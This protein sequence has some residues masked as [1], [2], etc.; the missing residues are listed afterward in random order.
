MNKHQKVAVIVWTLDPI[1]EKRF[2]LR[3]NKPF[4]GYSD[5]WTLVFGNIEL[6][7]TILECAKRETKEEFGISDF[8][9]IKDLKHKID[10][11]GKHG[12]TEIHF[13]S[14]ELE[15]I[16]VS[17]TLNEESIG[18]DWMT[19]NTARENMKHKDEA[20]ALDLV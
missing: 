6:E 19:K 9:T 2:L 16:D 10:F 1:G 3:H 14:L 18:Y 12:S 20:K 11:T 7:E 15:N 17:I 4:D 8:K 13:V 5:E